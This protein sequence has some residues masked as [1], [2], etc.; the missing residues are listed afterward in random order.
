MQSSRIDRRTT[1]TIPDHVLDKIAA[2]PA[3]ASVV[4][5]LRNPPPGTHIGA[6]E[7]HIANNYTRLSVGITALGIRD[8]YALT[9]CAAGRAF[10]D[11]S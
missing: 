7:R 4:A 10:G 8:F 11:Q 5:L 1:R 3:F 6:L 2:H 9:A